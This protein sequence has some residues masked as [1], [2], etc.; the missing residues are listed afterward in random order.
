MEGFNF[1]FKNLI[2]KCFIRKEI[3][4][5]DEQKKC[6]FAQK[7]NRAPFKHY[8]KDFGGSN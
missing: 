3:M 2:W 1:F 5:E 6:L 4:F 8:K 7:V